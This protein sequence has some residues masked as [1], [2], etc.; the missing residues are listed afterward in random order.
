MTDL[1]FLGDWKVWAGL[2]V[3]LLLAS[4]AWWL[5]RRETRARTDHLRWL[6]PGLRSL[7]V[8]LIVMMLTGPVLHHRQIIGQLARVI[9]FVDASQSMGITDEQMELSR[10]LLIAQKMGWLPTGK[11][12]PELTR[13]L[14]RLSAAEQQTR[15]AR[16]ELSSGELKGIAQ[17]ATRELEAAVD[18]VGKVTAATWSPGASPKKKLREEL[19]VPAQRL[20]SQNAGTNLKK[21]TGD[22][23]TLADGAVRWQAE[24]QKTV[25]DHV[26]RLVAANDES[27]KTALQKFDT[28]TRWQ[29]TEA[30]LLSGRDSLLADLATKHHIELLALA[31]L[32]PEVM[33][34]PG[35]G[36]LDQ[37]F[38]VPAS[39]PFAPTNGNTD[40]SD[41]LKSTV[42]QGKK[43]ERIAVVLF[44]D[45][46]HN[47]GSSPLQTAKI[48]GNRGIP[49][50]TV[51]LGSPSLPHDLAILQVKGP[52]T[53]F[54]EAR[55]KGEIMLKDDMPPGKP[56]VLKIEAGGRILWEKSLLTEQ[57]HLRAVPY[58][59][60]I[61]ELVQDELG[62]QDKQV[63]FNNLPLTMKVS[64][65]VV[66]GEKDKQNNVGTLRLSANTEKPKL[67]LLDGRP[68]WEFRYLRNLFERDE[69]WE[70]NSLLGGGGD[71]PWSR[72]NNPG[73][74][75]PDRESLFAYQLICFGDLPPAALRT[76]ELEWIREFV[77]K[78][79]GGII[80]VDGRQEQLASYVATPL[81]PMLPVN[82][83]GPPLGDMPF[84]LRLSAR[85]GAQ[86]PLSLVSD[87]KE[88]ADLWTALPAP[89][90]SAGTTALPGAETL[91]EAVAGTRVVP[92]LVFQRYGA[93]RVLYAGFDES[94]RWRYEVGDLYHQKFWNQVTKWIMEAPFPVQDKYVS[95]D[96][97]PVTYAPGETAEIRVRV[98]D[99]QGRLLLKAKAEAHVFRDGRKVA[100][101]ELAPDENQGG[102]LRG[103]TSA[104][105]PGLYE[106]RVRVDGLPESEM[107]A[108]TEFAVAAQ[109]SSELAQLNCDEELL[110]QLAF[111]SG[112]QYFREEDIGGLA[113]RL[114]PMS[115]GRII[116][117]ETVLW[118]SYWWFGPLVLVLAMEWFLRKR[119]GML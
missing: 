53:V 84:K 81:K 106:I 112:G 22:L 35:A 65:S 67:L 40:L 75:P 118:Q 96:S 58:E 71:K 91:L 109:G 48:L 94:W 12:D 56:F 3:A 83:S 52:D 115:E 49:I 29:R 113:E 28:F 101:V 90:W 31:N 25:A 93:G 76:E 64:A 107:K 47:A 103:K 80:F 88:N 33:W 117:S 42:E 95:L 38:Q 104:L 66:E 17:N 9:L 63:K 4:A 11:F 14:A 98:R 2:P 55:V 34:F 69:K 57:R 70:V 43:E 82:W 20:A 41:G 6:L 102:T 114:Q 78:R 59:L 39:F 72:G 99:G 21:F 32:K 44:S 73:E 79:G 26:H 105:L 8:F 7:A 45:G 23:Q 77:E 27:V 86:A 46:Q 60:S 74:F 89:H 92:A 110:R 19:L 30:M 85:G 100:T 68:R 54:Q 37:S 111:H 61:K 24:L 87:Q 116:E 50:F 15:A 16:A 5:Y 18:A 108:R 36:R 62:R 97:G 51:G 1:R 13:A 119:A 10:K